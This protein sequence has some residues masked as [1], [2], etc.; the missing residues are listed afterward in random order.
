[1]RHNEFSDRLGQCRQGHLLSAWQSRNGERLARSLH[2]QAAVATDTFRTI[3]FCRWA[4]WVSFVQ[5]E[6]PS[7]TSMK[8]CG[9]M[10]MVAFALDMLRHIRNV[11]KTS[12]NN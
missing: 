1:M 9:D 4:A 2:L 10:I 12:D 3:A 7:D 8:I 5:H 11:F 6:K